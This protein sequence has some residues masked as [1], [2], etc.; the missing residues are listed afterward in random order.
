MNECGLTHSLTHSLLGCA[1][2]HGDE[3]EDA[4]CLYAFRCKQDADQGAKASAEH[5]VTKYFGEDYDCCKPRG[6]ENGT[7]FAATETNAWVFSSFSFPLKTFSLEDNDT[8]MYG[9]VK[10][11]VI[12]S[13]HSTRDAAVAQMN[14]TLDQDLE[15]G[16]WRSI[17]VVQ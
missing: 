6:Q 11:E 1:G 14:S 17:D 16:H 3:V 9:V 5:T 8:M 15:K 4:D 2:M 12:Q 10:D 7:W 13:I